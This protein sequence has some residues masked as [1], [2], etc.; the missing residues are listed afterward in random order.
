MEICILKTAADEGRGQDL[1]A[2]WLDGY[3]IQGLVGYMVTKA[4]TCEE[5]SDSIKASHLSLKWWTQITL[6]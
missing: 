4:R 2:A 3:H 6:V 1:P 5:N